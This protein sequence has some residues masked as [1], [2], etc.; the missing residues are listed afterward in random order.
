MVFSTSVS[1]EGILTN[2]VYSRLSYCNSLIFNLSSSLI[3]LL[4]D[5]QNFSCHILFHHFIS[6]HVISLLKRLHKLPIQE[7]IKFKLLLITRTTLTLSS[8]YYIFYFLSV[9][10]QPPSLHYN[11]I[12]FSLKYLLIFYPQKRPIFCCGYFQNLELTPI[13]NLFIPITLLT[14]NLVED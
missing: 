11:L 6:S 5:V 12:G 4:Q 10:K 8:L 14:Q 2:S 9:N 7:Q 13:P 3:N 1:F